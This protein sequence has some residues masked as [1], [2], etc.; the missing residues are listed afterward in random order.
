[1]GNEEEEEEQGRME[2][3]VGEICRQAGRPAGVVG[4]ASCTTR[5]A[6]SAAAA[7]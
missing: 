2:C 6:A 3:T 7:A 4:A 1:M 5:V